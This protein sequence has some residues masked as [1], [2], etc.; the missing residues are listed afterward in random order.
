MGRNFARPRA[1]LDQE[2]KVILGQWPKRFL[3]LHRSQFDSYK[4]VLLGDRLTGCQ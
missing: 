4:L 2:M 3:R 1:Y